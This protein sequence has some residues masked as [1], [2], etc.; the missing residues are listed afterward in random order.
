[1]L[2]HLNGQDISF[3]NGESYARIIARAMPEVKPLGV[4][5]GGETLCLTARPKDGD[6]ASVITIASTEGRLISER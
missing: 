6:T 3:E 2:L 5:V 1:M 4:L